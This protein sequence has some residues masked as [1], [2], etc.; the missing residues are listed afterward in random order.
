MH[1]KPVL[2]KAGKTF[3]V[4]SAFKRV[5]HK[6]SFMEYPRMHQPCVII[7]KAKADSIFSFFLSANNTPEKR[8]KS[9]DFLIQSLV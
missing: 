8:I 4:V 3:K 1:G 7:L 2:Q 6:P 9:A 5:L